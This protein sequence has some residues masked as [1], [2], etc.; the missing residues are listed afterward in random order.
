[1]NFIHRATRL[2]EAMSEPGYMKRDMSHLYMDE[3][4]I[5]HKVKP[6]QKP[7]A[8]RPKTIIQIMHVNNINF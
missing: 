6:N 4:D 7:K 5:R 8:D 1:M 2:M 3:D